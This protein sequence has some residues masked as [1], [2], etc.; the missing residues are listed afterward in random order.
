MTNYPAKPT[1]EVRLKIKSHKETLKANWNECD[2][3]AKERRRLERERNELIKAATKDIDAALKL[4]NAESNKRRRSNATLHSKIRQLQDFGF[5]LK[6]N[7]RIYEVI[8]D[9]DN[10][11]L[12]FHTTTKEI[13]DGTPYKKVRSI[14]K[15]CLDEAREQNLI[16]DSFD[17]MKDGYIREES[18]DYWPYY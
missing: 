12:R 18:D 6:K 17:I 9:E 3:I 15:P 4:V 10:L 16:D 14:I 2:E 7:D 11:V 13:P 1:K 8:D 5:E